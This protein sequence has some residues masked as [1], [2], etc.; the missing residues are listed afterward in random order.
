MTVKY[1]D[2]CGAADSQRAMVESDALRLNGAAYDVCGT[3]KKRLL[4]VLGS[5]GWAQASART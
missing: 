5:K 4:T 2:F 3:C 1:C